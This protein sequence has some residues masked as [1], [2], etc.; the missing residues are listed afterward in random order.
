M[1]QFGPF[2]PG[3]SASHAQVSYGSSSSDEQDFENSVS[4]VT[5]DTSSKTAQVAVHPTDEETPLLGGRQDSED[6]ATD[7][8]TQLTKS[9]MVILLLGELLSHADTTLIFAAAPQIASELGSLRGIG[10]LATSYTLGVCSMQPLYGRLSDIFGR[11]HML[12][13]A[14]AVL[15]VGCILCGLSQSLVQIIVSRAISGIGG[16]GVMTMASIIITD[17]VPRSKFATYRSYINLATTLGRSIGGPIGG[18]IADSMGWH[19]LFWCRLPFFALSV[20]LILTSLKDEKYSDTKQTDNS[21]ESLSPSSFRQKW[22]KVDVK[23]ALLLTKTIVSLILLLDT[24]EDHLGTPQFWLLLV[25]VL[26]FGQLFVFVEIFGT[27]SPIFNLRILAKRNV[28]LSYLVDYLQVFSQVGMMFSVPLYFQVTQRASAAKSGAH[29]VPAVIA[30]TIGA[31]A[32]GKMLQATHRHKIILVLVGLLG[33]TSYIL[34]W[35]RWNGD[36]HFWESLYVIAGGFAT[37]VAQSASFVTMSSHLEK[38]EVAM[39]TGGFFLASSLGTVTAVTTVNVL[40][41]SFFTRRLDTV[42][43]IPNKEELI[44]KVTSNIDNISKL[45]GELRN[46]VVGAF[47]G[48]L[49]TTYSKASRGIES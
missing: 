7:E 40:L 8:G 29:I 34:I 17:S 10:W 42:V 6:G 37:G 19:W 32:S 21:D 27:N 43:D 31:L 23:G 5:H 4:R 49:K 26:T 38:Q 2:K 12:L 14:Y 28:A 44:K 16:A 45:T 9:V 33:A 46:L 13:F 18:F 36:T 25:S 48:S 1:M 11:K 20:A 3:G 35:A 22:A 39:A 41:Q 30:N 15:S 47:V 24:V